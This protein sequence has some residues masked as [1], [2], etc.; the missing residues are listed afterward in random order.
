LTAS[1]HSDLD[2]TR[3][4]RVRPEVIDSDAYYEVAQRSTSS[5]RWTLSSTTIDPVVSSINR[6]A[7]SRCAPECL[8]YAV[9]EV[10]VERGRTR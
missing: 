3:G 8:D 5:R 4:T 2:S 6:S 10:V 7:D 9:D 1:T